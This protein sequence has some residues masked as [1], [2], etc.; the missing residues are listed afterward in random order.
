V[1]ATESQTGRFRQRRRTRSA[2]VNAAAELLRSGITTPGVSEIAAA[3]DVSR[4][5]VYQYFPTV[6]QLL[7][8]ATLGLLSQTAVDNAIGQSDPGGDALDRVSAMIR[9]LVGLSSQTM[10]LGRSLVRLTVDAPADST[11][12]PKRGYRR[13]SWIE[14]AIEPLRS[15]LDE[16][17][18]E[19]LVSAL[20]MVIGWE[21]LIVLQDLRGL[22]PDEQIDVSTWAAH[23]L[24]Q[25][26]L[27]EQ[28]MIPTT[29]SQQRPAPAH[30]DGPGDAKKVVKGSG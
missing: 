21:A 24:I 9:A 6:E 14:T 17:G 19:R 12:Q 1:S 23:A 5:T 11:G 13:I 3:A 15:E 28:A 2:I 20:A 22:T 30:R 4:R 26:A 29:P 25:G 7:L 18:F 8:D 27:Q 10:P 16:A